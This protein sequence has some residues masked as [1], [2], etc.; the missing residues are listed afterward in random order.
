MHEEFELQRKDWKL[1]VGAKQAQYR[2]VNRNMIIQ[3]DKKYKYNKR[4]KTTNKIN[5]RKFRPTNKNI[6]KKRDN[7]KQQ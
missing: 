7:Y 5:N 1:A 6:W 2:E 3:W 4:E